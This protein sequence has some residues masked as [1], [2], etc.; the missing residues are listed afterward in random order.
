MITNP[1]EIQYCLER[2][3]KHLIDPLILVHVLGMDVYEGTHYNITHFSMDI[4]DF[5]RSLFFLI[6][7]Y[8]LYYINNV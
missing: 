6:K 8:T 7:L 3:Q 5:F 2:I 4:Y 1:I